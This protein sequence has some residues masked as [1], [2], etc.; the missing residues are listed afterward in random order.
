M[1]AV[2]WRA[3]LYRV[4]ILFRGSAMIGVDDELQGSLSGTSLAETIAMN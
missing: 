2:K 3:R 4:K 1:G